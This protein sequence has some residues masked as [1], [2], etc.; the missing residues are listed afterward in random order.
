M[1][2][3]SVGSAFF[4]DCEAPASLWIVLRNFKAALTRRPVLLETGQAVRKMILSS[5]ENKNHKGGNF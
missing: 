5:Q 4:L 1:G 3:P 2:T